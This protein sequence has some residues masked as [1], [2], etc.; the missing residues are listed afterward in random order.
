MDAGDPDT[1]A[2][3]KRSLRGGSGPLGSFEGGQ[4][5]RGGVSERKMLE[6]D[7]SQEKP[8]NPPSPG[9]GPS[10]QP[11]RAKNESLGVSAGRFERRSFILGWCLTGNV[12]PAPR[13]VPPPPIPSIPSSTVRP[14]IGRAQRR[15]R[16]PPMHPEPPAKGAENSHS[17]PMP[18]PRVAPPPTPLGAE[19]ELGRHP[20]SRLPRCPRR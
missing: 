15:P 7:L 1:K 5:A 17:L 20:P 14:N 2:G 13:S 10:G 9:S 11:A 12:G 8:T 4:C 16:S 6:K 3:P 18:V 19:T